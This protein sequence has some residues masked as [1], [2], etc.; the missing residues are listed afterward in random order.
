MAFSDSVKQQALLRASGR[1]ECAR[2][3]HNHFGF[4]GRCGATLT[5]GAYEFNHRVSQLAGGSDSLANCEVLCISC[6]RATRSY[7]AH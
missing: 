4:L 7:G 1:C 5:A 2:K 6:H 3:E